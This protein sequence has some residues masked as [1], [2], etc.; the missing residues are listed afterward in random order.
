MTENAE[1]YP[2][3]LDLGGFFYIST[4]LVHFVREASRKGTLENR[5][6]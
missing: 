2:K 6:W 5:T 4:F 1:K 3:L